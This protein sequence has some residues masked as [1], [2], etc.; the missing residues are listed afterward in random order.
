[1]TGP[2]EN[3]NKN[4]FCKFHGVKGHST[5]GCIH[6]KRQIE[7]AVKLG[8]LS[9]LV[10]EIKQGGKRGEQA[11]AV[12]KAETPKEKAAAI[13][14]VQPWERETPIVIKAEVEGHLIHRMYV[15]GGSAS[16]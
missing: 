11:K 15:D 6:L 14:M 2:A 1:M 5:D 12:K 8:Q 7:E 9:H 4:K 10:K 13:F 16:E 3:Q